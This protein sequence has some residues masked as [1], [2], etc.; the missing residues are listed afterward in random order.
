MATQIYVFN[1]SPLAIAL[2]VRS[3]LTPY[4]FAAASGGS[5]PAWTPPGPNKAIA[6][7]ATSP[8]SGQLGFGTNPCALNDGQTLTTFNIVIPTGILPTT[9]LQIYLF[10]EPPSSPSG[11]GTVGY[12]VLNDGFPIGGNIA[13]FSAER[14]MEHAAAAHSKANN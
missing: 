3:G 14:A 7:G 2:T 12:V 8:G 11:N 10:Y 5:T 6:W 1:C 13:A 9:S 4:T